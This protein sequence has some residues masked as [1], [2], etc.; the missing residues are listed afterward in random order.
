MSKL[1]F[2]F[3]TVEKR[4]VAAM[5]L[6]S[7]FALSVLAGQLKLGLLLLKI[8][9]TVDLFK[10]AEPKLSEIS[11]LTR[12]LAN[13]LDANF[14]LF[15]G[16]KAFINSL[17]ITDLGFI[18]MLIIL[19]QGNKTSK[20][21]KIPYFV[22]AIV[23]IMQ[24]I[25]YAFCVVATVYAYR[26]TSGLQ[27]AQLFK[28]MGIICTSITLVEMTLIIGSSIHVYYSLMSENIKKHG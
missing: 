8:E 20:S 22:S 27:A 10:L 3:D 11:L 19:L 28:T 23:I 7:I 5:L 9:T 21:E 13:Y 1:D 2:L 15:N 26:A 6:L 17:R 12:F 25:L 14:S 24:A 18:L 16:V 4:I